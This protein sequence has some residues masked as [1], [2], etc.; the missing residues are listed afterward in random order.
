MSE[1]FPQTAINNDL[2]V[3]MISWIQRH[4]LLLKP[5]ALRRSDKNGQ[6]IL[7]NAFLKFSLKIILVSFHLLACAIIL[8]AAVKM[9]TVFHPLMNV[10]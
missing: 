9:S 4:C 8:L 1:C 6:A 7:S 3:V 2:A 10:D 5:L